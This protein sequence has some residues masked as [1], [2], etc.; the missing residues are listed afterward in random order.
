LGY[1]LDIKFTKVYGGKSEY[2][3]YLVINDEKK[4]IFSNLKEHESQ[5][6]IIGTR[7]INSNT[8]DVVDKIISLVQ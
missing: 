2:Y 8:K 5:G 1:A 7:L 3:L 4:I 6:A